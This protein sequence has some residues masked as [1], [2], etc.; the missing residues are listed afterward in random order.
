MT[1]LYE[2]KPC[3]ILQLPVVQWDGHLHGITT[4]TLVNSGDGTATLIDQTAIAI[5]YN[6]KI[7]YYNFAGRKSVSFT[8]H[9]ITAAVYHTSLCLLHA[10]NIT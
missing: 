6:N 2:Y 8:F 10:T 4:V 5:P 3:H 7:I 1:L 9:S